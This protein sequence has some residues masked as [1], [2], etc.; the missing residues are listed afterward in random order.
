M[1]VSIKRIQY[2]RNQ[3]RPKED[4]NIYSYIYT[5]IRYDVNHDTNLII[6]LINDVASVCNELY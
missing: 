6:I 3:V 5:S 4:I 1:V 2:L